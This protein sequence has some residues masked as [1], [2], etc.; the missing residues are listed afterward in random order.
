MRRAVAR[1]PIGILLEQCE[2]KVVVGAFCVLER[3]E[4]GGW[5]AM[6][7]QYIRA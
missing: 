7:S 3:F 4:R 5:S 2:G 6:A 1:L